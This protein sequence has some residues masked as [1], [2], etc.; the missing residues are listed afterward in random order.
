[1]YLQE[2]KTNLQQAFEVTEAFD[3]CDFRLMSFVFQL[4][5]KTITEILH[6]YDSIRS[7]HKTTIP[8]INILKLSQ[9]GPFIA[10]IGNVG[11]CSTVINF[12]LNDAIAYGE[13]PNFLSHCKKV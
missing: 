9:I 4:Y 11:I 2:I 6:L 8:V 5:S 7:R 1:M 10:N 13:L 3:C 12:L